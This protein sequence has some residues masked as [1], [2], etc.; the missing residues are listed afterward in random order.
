VIKKALRLLR[1]A[2][3]L[4]TGGRI[5]AVEGALA[6]EARLCVVS[7]DNFVQPTYTATEVISISTSGAM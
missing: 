1:Y 4:D 2:T 3:V 6:D 5:A 7:A